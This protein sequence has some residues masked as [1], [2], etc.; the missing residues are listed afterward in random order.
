[1]NDAIDFDAAISARDAIAD[2]GVSV[3]MRLAL[4][5]AIASNAIAV[6]DAA[7]ILKVLTITKTIDGGNDDLLAILAGDHARALAIE[8]ATR[9]GVDKAAHGV[10]EAETKAYAAWQ[11]CSEG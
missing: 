5:A 1:M 9:A 10:A 6:A 4:N 8:Y 11:A 7:H 2:D 3:V